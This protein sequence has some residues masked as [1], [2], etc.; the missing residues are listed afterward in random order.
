MT[1]THI[2]LDVAN[3]DQAV[4][5]YQS[6]LGVGPFR[7]LPGYAQFL[8]EEPALNLALSERPSAPHSAGHFGIE[9]PDPSM[10]DQA[11]ARARKSGLNPEMEAN[12]ICCHSRQE[13]FW[14]RDPDGYRWEVFWV[15]ERWTAVPDGAPA[16]GCCAG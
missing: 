11:L 13:K 4:R 3:I 10:V 1:R 15:R 16:C 7:L 14:V 12:T 9:V 8:L 2:A 6:F 5:F